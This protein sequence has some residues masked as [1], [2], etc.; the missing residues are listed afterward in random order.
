MSSKIPGHKSTKSVLQSKIQ[1]KNILSKLICIFYRKGAVWLLHFIEWSL[2]SQL[3]VS[4]HTFPD[5]LNISCFDANRATSLA[6]YFWF[7]WTPGLKKK[8]P[9]LSVIANSWCCNPLCTAGLWRMPRMRRNSYP[10]HQEGGITVKHTG[11]AC[12][13][14]SS[15][16]QVLTWGNIKRNVSF[17]WEK[18]KQFHSFWKTF[19][20]VLPSAPIFENQAIQTLIIYLIL[21]RYWKIRGF[22]LHFPTKAASLCIWSIRSIWKSDTQNNNAFSSPYHLAVPGSSCI[23]STWLPEAAFG[24]PG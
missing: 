18:K 1:G 10:L 20:R 15:M 16:Q 19:G 22:L 17:T 13:F 3:S 6:G 4:Y 2:T 21:A 8:S 7:K 14:Y 5:R 12:S 24:K 9:S 23:L 11:H